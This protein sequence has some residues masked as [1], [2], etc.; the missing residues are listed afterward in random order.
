[1]TLLK[2]V[3]PSH[4]LRTDLRRRLH[5]LRDAFA[6]RA[7]E[8]DEAMGRHLG[9][10]LEA[11]Q[12]ECLGLYWPV[13]SEFNAASACLADTGLHETALALPYSRREPPAMQY[14]LWNRAAPTLRD[15]C[16][17]PSI[18]GAPVVPDVVLAPCLGYTRSGLRIGYGGG[19]FDR[20]LAAH[21]HVTA[22]G[23]AW[24]VCEVLADQIGA[25]AHD[26]PMMMIVTELGVVSE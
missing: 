13:R 1:M 10:L 4:P 5:G 9:Q 22:V 24:S 18:D 12:P 17:V 7:D 6:A 2:P 11:L 16:R 14:R 15:E 21:P 25:E 20:F 26:V 8:H 19:F 3:N 23:V